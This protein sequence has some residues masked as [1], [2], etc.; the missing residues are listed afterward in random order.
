MV[1][2]M[3]ARPMVTR[4]TLL[5]LL[6]STAPDVARVTT[7]VVSTTAPGLVADGQCSIVEA[8]ENAN[9]GAVVHTDCGGGPGPATIQ[10]PPRAEIRFDVPYGSNGRDA[11]PAITG[12][13]TIEGDTTLARTGV[14]PFRLLRVA[15]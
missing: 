10:L 9:A 14:V 1:F 7:I 12:D 2:T 6:C 15:P 5:L 8:V 13:V 11:L 4:A 3:P